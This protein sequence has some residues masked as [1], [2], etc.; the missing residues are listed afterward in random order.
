M[1]VAVV[2]F[3]GNTG[4]STLAA[5]L[6]VPRIEAQL[7][8][9]ESVGAD[10]GGGGDPFGA[11]HEQWLTIGATVID[12]GASRVAAFLKYLRQYRGAHEDF[13][14]F[15]VPTVRDQKQQ[16]DSVRTIEAL[17]EI[18]V[19]PDRIR[20]VFNRVKR[21]DLDSFESDF[22][23]ILSVGQHQRFRLSREAIVFEN[24][25][26]AMLK[27]L[28]RSIAQLLADNTDYRAKFRASTDAADK[29]LCLDRIAARR[30]AV[31]ANV[32]LDNVFAVL[33]PERAG[34]VRDAA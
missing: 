14:A 34:K 20:V 19:A 1:K 31:A 23:T 33:F 10:G 18:G 28:E 29:G 12:V 30:L 32:N 5:H 24:E 21:W 27:A 26:Y 8:T 13:D 17:G 2:N 3:S 6:L 11:L 22:Q 15:V 9:V 25:I 16:D 7:I 4:K